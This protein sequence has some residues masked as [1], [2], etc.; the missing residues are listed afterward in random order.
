MHPDNRTLIDTEALEGLSQDR[1]CEMK[2]TAW[3]MSSVSSSGRDNTSEVR[4]LVISNI[5]RGEKHTVVM[6]AAMHFLKGISQ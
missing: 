4:L 5:L 1:N 2:V 6:A 3:S